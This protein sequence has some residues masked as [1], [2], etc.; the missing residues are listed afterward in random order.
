MLP[1]GKRIIEK[2]EKIIDEELIEAGAQ[3]CDMP[4][5]GD[6]GLWSKTNRWVEMG[7]E[8][9]R[10]ED[11]LHGHYCLQPTAEEMFTTMV[12]EFGGL[13]KTQFPLMIFQV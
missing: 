8:M 13:R 5:L 9:Y 1:I 12:K 3:K 10:I 2:L 6:K 11:R 4:L 7:S